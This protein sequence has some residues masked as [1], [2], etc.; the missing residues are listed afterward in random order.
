VYQHTLHIVTTTM[1]MVPLIPP[2]HS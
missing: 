1:N 2:S